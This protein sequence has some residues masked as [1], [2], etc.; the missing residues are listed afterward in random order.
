MSDEDGDGI[1]GEE[2]LAPPDWRVR[3]RPRNNPTLKEREE[4]EAT[5]VP[6]RHW[7]T[8][9]MIGR[10]RTHH[11]TTKQEERG[12]VEKTY[13][14]DGLFAHE[15]EVC[16]GCATNDK[17]SI[18]CIAMLE[19]RHQNI[20]STVALKMGVEERWTAKKVTKFMHLLGYR[21]I[22][23][24][25]DTE[26]AMLAFTNR[27]AEMYKAEITTE[28]AVKGDRAS[29]G[30]IENAVMLIRGIIRTIKCHIASNTQEPT[31]QRIT[32]PAVVGGTCRMHLVHR[33][34]R[35]SKDGM[36]RTCHSNVSH[37]VRKCWQ[38][39]SSQ[40]PYEW[41]MKSREKSTLFLSVVW[42]INLCGGSWVVLSDRELVRMIGVGISFASQTKLQ[43]HML[44]G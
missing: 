19:D 8:H 34:K 36:A 25:S 2:E 17:I 29:N 7:C 13:H 18:I 28:D 39:K 3:A 15:N 22:P 30:L 11:H 10:G 33:G 27:V 5:H 20:M 26:L 1:V 12:S 42:W 23:L 31:R 6:F 24:K 40:I 44:I 35:H 32:D 21:E 14:C 41:C 9:C 4:P 43:T 37:L 38:S 16:C